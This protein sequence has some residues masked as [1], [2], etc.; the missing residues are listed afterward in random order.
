MQKLSPPNILKYFFGSANWQLTL[1]DSH[2]EV[3]VRKNSEKI[4]YLSIEKAKLAGIISANLQIQAKGHKR[5]VLKWS[6][7]FVSDEKGNSVSALEIKNALDEKVESIRAQEEQS[8]YDNM[9][10]CYIANRDFQ[11][12]R[13]SLSYGADQFFE[14]VK[15]RLSERNEDFIL[16]EEKRL[17]EFFDAVESRQLTEEQRRAAIVMEDNNLLVAAAGS[18]KTS[19]II[20]KVGY[21]LKKGYCNPSE[22]LLLAFNKK[23]AK[24]MEERI[25]QRLGGA[26]KGVTVKTFHK[27]GLDIIAQAEQARPSVASWIPSLGESSGANK[28]WEE[29]INSIA[30]KDRKFSENLTELFTYF[31][32]AIRPAHLFRSKSEYEQYLLAL[33]VKKN[34]DT[35]RENWGAPTING[36]YVRS[37]EEAAIANW[38]Y[39]NNVEYEHETPYEHATANEQYR[40]YKPDFYYPQ[41]SVYHEHFALDESGK[42]P[43]FFTPGYEEG[44]QWKREIHS[45]YNTKL[46]ETSSAMFKQ[47]DIFEHLRE[48]LNVHGVK[49]RKHRMFAEITKKLQE[50][51]VRPLYKIMATFLTHWKSS[52]MSESQLIQ[53]ADDLSW[54]ERL[55]TRLFVRIMVRVRNEYDAILH[56]NNEIDFEDML[57]KAEEHLRSG[58]WRHPYKIILVDEFQDVSRSLTRLLK[59][60]LDQAPDCKMFAVGD[61]WQSIYRFAGADVSV[62]ADC[63]AIFGATATNYLRTTFR[64]NQ[65]IVN[66]ATAFVSRNPSQLSKE[67][68]AQDAAVS[69]VVCVANYVSNRDLVSFVE[70]QLL[71]ISASEQHAKVYI[72]ARYKSLRPESMEKWQKRFGNVLDIE[73]STIHSVKGREA[74]YVFVLGMDVGRYGFPSEI[75]DDPVLQMVKPKSE[76]FL[77]AEERRLFYVALTRA[78]R[79]A[80]LLTKKKSPSPF[81]SEILANNQESI[82]E[83][84]IVGGG[85]LEE[86]ASLPA[87]PECDGLLEKRNG[88]FGPF[89]GC[90]NY[91]KCEYTQ[92]IIK[93]ESN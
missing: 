86:P 63:A 27:C 45:R 58:R 6:N 77:H 33:R 81:I 80:F 92:P 62:M 68:K 16:R 36:E 93:S 24:E 39:V 14:E 1:C 61:D 8:F 40:Q 20:G 54:Y 42:A 85:K 18:G 52:G 2:C 32:W 35:D 15:K 5:N 3:I 29:M 87:C 76:K 4:D 83:C 37:L 46:I 65:G 72:L 60:M 89:L 50:Q 13:N 21:L 64:S 90:S 17:R 74:D 69:R 57:C 11:Q 82:Y 7:F 71:K 23:A 47:N 55:R 30:Y 31:R 59:A 48:Q 84:D 49:F 53:D 73:F 88:R 22:I 79:K 12:W 41:I 75:E 44:V 43:S 19:V 9:Q 51:F 38:L 66:V 34:S 56:A 28:K 78:R 26:A 70:R 91:P 25:K 67:V 10:D